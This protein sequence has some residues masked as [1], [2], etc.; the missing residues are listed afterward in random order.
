MSYTIPLAIVLAFGLFIYE[1]LKLIKRK[2]IQNKKLLK[3]VK[4]KPCVICGDQS[5]SAHIKS[6]GSGGDDVPEN[7]ISLCRKH[8]QTQHR[9]GWFKMSQ[10]Y[11]EVWQTLK[12]NGWSFENIFGITKLVR[13]K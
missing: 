7:M 3:D 11:V 12:N 6:R 13:W 2:R 1:E 5:D 4:K 9:I 10:R 8:H